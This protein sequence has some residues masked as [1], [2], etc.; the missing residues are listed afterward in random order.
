MKLYR[1]KSWKTRYEN[2]RTRELKKLDWIPVPNQQDGEGY[3]IT[4]E[5]KDGA[6]LLGAWMVILQV[7]SKCGDC[8]DTR[9]TL[10]RDTGQPHDSTSLSRLTRLPK[11]IL[12]KALEHF[13]SNE[14]Q[15][16]EVVDSESLETI[17]QVD[18]EIPQAG[19]LKEGK[20]RK[21]GMEGKGLAETIVD[22]WNEA[23]FARVKLLSADRAT[24]LSARM[25]SKFWMEHYAEALER[26]K[27][28][29]FCNGR[30]VRQGK[31]AWFANFDWFVRNDDAVACLVEGKYDN[32]VAIQKPISRPEA[33]K[34]VDAQPLD[35]I[36]NKKP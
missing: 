28:S 32:R 7:A 34:P 23:G 5:H 17:P 12:D 11:A 21:K 1:V 10:K 25:K 19:A 13:S 14:M 15:W 9:G 31:E 22:A 3:T 29:D 30:N 27:A 18:A 36:W 2:N 35:E 26:A 6:S 8:A 16:L 24:K 20:G 33:P 4:A